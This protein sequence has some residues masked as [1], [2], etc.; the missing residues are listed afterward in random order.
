MLGHNLRGSSHLMRDGDGGGGLGALERVTKLHAPTA[1]D[2]A[3]GG[4]GRIR[5]LSATTVPVLKSRSIT[6]AHPGAQ[7]RAVIDNVAQRAST[8]TMYKYTHPVAAHVL[9]QG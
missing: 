1:G 4:C 9:P 7:S 3:G 6:C 8:R 2:G 5:S